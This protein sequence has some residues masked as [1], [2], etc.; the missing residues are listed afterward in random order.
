[1]RYR[2]SLAYS[3]KV[4][5]LDLTGG[6]FAVRCDDDDTEIALPTEAVRPYEPPPLIYGNA[7]W[8]C[9]TRSPAIVKVLE[10]V[11]YW[12]GASRG[13]T[14]E[15]EFLSLWLGLV[16]L[17]QSESVDYIAAV[18]TRCR[19]ALMIQLLSRWIAEYLRNAYQL[20]WSALT[21]AD[22][23]RFRL[24]RALEQRLAPVASAAASRRGA[25]D[26]LGAASPFLFRRIQLLTALCEKETRDRILRR[27]EG[28]L[29]VL[30]PWVRTV[31]HGVAHLGSASFTGMDLVNQHLREYLT[32]CYDQLAA[33]ALRSEIRSVAEAHSETTMNFDA[34]VDKVLREPCLS[35]LHVRQGLNHVTALPAKFWAL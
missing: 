30:L 9:R 11:L 8:I 12:L 3:R 2:N 24:D 21:P 6:N 20:N 29:H 17:H 28:E 10:Q 7:V 13:A 18:V 35:V 27:L 23:K 14:G 22:V 26:R 5:R 33:S 1:M 34:I 19:V 31:R 4:E 25:F 15:S 16:S 32:L